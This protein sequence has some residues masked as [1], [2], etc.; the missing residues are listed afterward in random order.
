MFMQ[1]S[2]ASRIPPPT[3]S[4]DSI[5]R[6][7]GAGTSASRSRR[8]SVMGGASTI[9]PGFI[10]FPGSNSRFTRRIA[11]YSSS[12]KISRLNCE[13]AS[14]SPCSLELTPP[15]SRTRFLIFSATTRIVSTCAGSVRSTNGRMCRHPTEQWP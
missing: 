3:T 10:V 9:L 12:P 14:P 2:A 1:R 13:R 5:V 11:S 4:N 6:S 7:G 15:Y 8:L